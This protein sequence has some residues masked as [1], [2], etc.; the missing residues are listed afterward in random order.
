LRVLDSDADGEGFGFEGDAL[1]VECGEGVARAVADGEDG[2][3]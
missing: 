3:I 1:G 2:L